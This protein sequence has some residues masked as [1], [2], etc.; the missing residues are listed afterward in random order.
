MENNNFKKYLKYVLIIIFAVF[1]ILVGYLIGRNKKRQVV[2]EV[3]TT[4]KQ[5]DQDLCNDVKKLG[6]DHC[7]NMKDCFA[8]KKYYKD[9][10]FTW[11]DKDKDGIPC[12]SLC[13]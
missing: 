11:L 8:A 12:E 13:R 10:N 5:L 7:D 9:C 2:N 6:L 4:D 1:L 3:V